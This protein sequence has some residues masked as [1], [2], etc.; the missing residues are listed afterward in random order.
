MDFRAVLS[1]QSVLVFFISIFLSLMTFLSVNVFHEYSISYAFLFSAIIA[2]F[3]AGIMRLIGGAPGERSIKLRESFFTVTLA[4]IL[5]SLFGAFPYIF[6]GSIPSFTDAYFESMS[7]F[8]TTGASILTDIESMPRSILFWRA[9]TNFVGGGGIVVLTVAI[10]PALSVGGVQLV[11]KEA[12]SPLGQK[13]FPKLKEIARQIWIIYLTLNVLSVMLLL[14]GGMSWFDAFSH[15]FAAVATGGFS[16]YNNSVGYYAAQGHPSAL[17]FEIVLSV[18]MLLGSIGFYLQFSLL[19]GDISVVYKDPQLRFYLSIV[20][21]SIL[22]IAAHL[23]LSEH[24][25]DLGHGLRFAS[26]SVISVITTT[27]F[28]TADFSRWPEFDRFLLVVL[29]FIGGM[30]GSTAGGMKPMRVL[31]G[32]KQSFYELFRSIHPKQVYAMKMGEQFLSLDQVRQVNTFLLTYVIVYAGGMLTLSFFEKDFET[33]A[34]MA[35]AALSSIGPGTSVENGPAANYAF[36]QPVSKW[37]FT[38]LMLLGRLELYPVLVIL[39]PW[40]WRNL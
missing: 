21:V 13:K 6:S 17:Y 15:T 12:S 27:G 4:W 7:G 14:A 11:S 30:T 3:S 38:F 2:F 32:M 35:I 31:V 34:T 16:P 37:V 10:L 25:T 1:M 22:F 26:F 20:F 33:V 36:A 8:T 9:M 39:T 40:Y 5:M 19:R 28:G 23:F 18:F 29:M 24:V